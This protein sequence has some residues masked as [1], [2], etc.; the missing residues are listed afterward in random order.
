MEAIVYGLIEIIDYI[1]G[2]FE[3][4][5]NLPVTVDLKVV[6]LPIKW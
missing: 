5:K 3:L 4:K 6:R 2:D 1:F